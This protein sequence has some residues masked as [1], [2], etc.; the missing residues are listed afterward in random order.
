MFNV[1]QFEER[2]EKM[3]NEANNVIG[4][5]KDAEPFDKRLEAKLEHRSAVHARERSLALLVQGDRLLKR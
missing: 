2:D 5:R 1:T 4:Y 3:F